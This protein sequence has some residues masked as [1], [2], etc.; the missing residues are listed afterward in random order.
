MIGFPLER[1]A[2]VSALLPGGHADYE[3]ATLLVNPLI[4]EKELHFAVHLRAVQFIFRKEAAIEQI[5]YQVEN[6]DQ[7]LAS[8]LQ[9]LGFREL[10]FVDSAG[11]HTW[12]GCLRD[13]FLMTKSDC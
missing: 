3:I 2:H 9:S 5:L 4:Q 12:Y 13:E 11:A 1:K 10:R 8:I 7:T 6:Q